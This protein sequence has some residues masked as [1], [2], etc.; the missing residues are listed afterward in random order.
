VF[1]NDTRMQSLAPATTGTVTLFDCRGRTVAA[2]RIKGGNV[3]MR[4]IVPQAY[5]AVISDR[6]Q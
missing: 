4:G 3:V 1:G 5:L 6:N 2:A